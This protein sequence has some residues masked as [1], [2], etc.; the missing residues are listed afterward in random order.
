M[1]K[2]VNF[3]WYSAFQLN[4]YCIPLFSRHL[5]SKS[6]NILNHSVAMK[7]CVRYCCIGSDLQTLQFSD[8]THAVN[9]TSEVKTTNNASEFLSPNDWFIWAQAA[10][11]P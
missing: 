10:F 4:S 11:G 8:Y 2:T 7:H 9:D 6:L 5:H 1:K 3:N